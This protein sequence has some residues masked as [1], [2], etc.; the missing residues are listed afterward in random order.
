MKFHF[1]LDFSLM[2]STS[3][4]GNEILMVN[5]YVMHGYVI[6]PRSVL[7]AKPTLIRNFSLKLLLLRLL[8]SSEALIVHR[9]F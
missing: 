1:N 5:L 7:S 6:K 9:V 4:S 2:T 3:G 8:S